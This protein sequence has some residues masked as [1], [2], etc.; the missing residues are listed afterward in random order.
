MIQ[1]LCLS[2]CICILLVHSSVWAAGWEATVTVMS[3]KQETVPIQLTFGVDSAALDWLDR[4]DAVLPPAGRGSILDA[5]FTIRDPDF[6]RLI[7]DIRKAGRI[8]QWQL[9]IQA[10]TAD[11]ILTW[12]VSEIPAGEFV[13]LEIDNHIIEMQRSS[14]LHLG[15]GIH[16]LRITMVNRQGTTSVVNRGKQ[17]LTWG[18]IRSCS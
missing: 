4:M 1:K 15:A 14:T 18:Y 17:R 12:D 7:K 10:N 11:L 6:P 3:E 5:A 9:E 13:F 8:H 2:A 16:R